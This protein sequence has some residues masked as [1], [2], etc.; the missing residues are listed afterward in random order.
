MD[1]LYEQNLSNVFILPESG[2]SSGYSTRES[3]T[4]QRLRWNFPPGEAVGQMVLF[5]LSE[6]NH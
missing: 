4:I 6:D 3:S 5:A 2:E 1:R